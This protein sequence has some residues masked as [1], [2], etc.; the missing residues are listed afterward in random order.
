MAKL[1]V[2]GFAGAGTVELGN[3]DFH[4][5]GLGASE[6]RSRELGIG[7]AMSIA[8]AA[9]KGKSLMIYVITDGS[10]SSRPG[11]AVAGDHV[12]YSSEDGDVSSAVMIVYRHP[13]NAEMTRDNTPILNDYMREGAQ[14]RRQV[15]FYR[16]G[17]GTTAVNTTA[18]VV[19]TNSVSNLAIA[20][21]ANYMALHGEDASK[22]SGVIKADVP[23]SSEYDKYVGFKKIV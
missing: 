1:V 12:Q 19:T 6:A 18:G 2:D 5:T 17:N 11:N 4:A 3:C 21:V 9:S 8:I 10:A 15:G 14:G 22:V 16:V 23:F 20:A 7:I 13:A